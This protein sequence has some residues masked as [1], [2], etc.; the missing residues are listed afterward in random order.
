[1]HQQMARAERLV[2]LGTLSAT[3]VHKMTQPLTVIRLSLDNA[4]DELEGTSCPS[5]VLRKLCDSVAQVSN[6]TA[7]INQFRTFARQSSD[8]DIGQASV[9][10]VV[11]R[12]VR[13]LA[14][15]AKQAR[16]KLQVEDMSH[17]PPVALHEREFEQVLFALIEN[18]IQAADG[19]GSRRIVVGGS[20]KDE[21][22]EMRFSDNCGG[23]A[24][25][26]SDRIFEPFFTTKPRGKGTGLG[27]CIVQD[28][29]V[30]AGGHVRVESKFGKGS[31][32]FVTLPVSE[33]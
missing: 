8:T 26:N 23:I 1:Y 25:E 6:I 15:S 7:I 32:F 4:M 24:A 30:R 27:L 31:T 11:V 14:E 29:V 10:A 2:S 12:V 20:V 9:Q 5:T 17:L 18:A 33:D 22:I 3:I 21:R 16:V 28:A 13:L 19:E